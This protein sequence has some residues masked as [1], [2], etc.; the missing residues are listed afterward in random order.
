[1][2]SGAALADQELMTLAEVR[3]AEI[4]PRAAFDPDVAVDW[5]QLMELHDLLVRQAGYSYDEY[6]NWVAATLGAALVPD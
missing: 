1:L 4:E 6:E 5:Q 3:F 2:R